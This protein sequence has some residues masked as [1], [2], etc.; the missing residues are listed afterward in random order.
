MFSLPLWGLLILY[1]VLVFVSFHK[2]SNIAMGLRPRLFTLLGAVFLIGGFLF[3]PWVKFDF[4]KYFVEA[5]DVIR[6]FSPQVYEILFH[7]VGVKGLAKFFG[8]FSMVTN[9]SGWQLQ[10][11]PVYPW[12][13]RLFTL[14]PLL[15]GGISLIW[16]PIGSNWRG[17]IINRWVGGALMVFSSISLLLLILIS[18]EIDSMGGYANFQWAFFTTILGAR[19]GRGLWVTILGLCF[20]IIGGWNEYH[21][22]QPEDL[23]NDLF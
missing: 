18:S 5:P 20:T 2:T 10:L 16:V 19:I 23:H 22:L 13:V 11:I 7:S 12:H 6:N 15:I 14:I 4:L 17:R 1:F 9:L 21:D 3:E 8:I